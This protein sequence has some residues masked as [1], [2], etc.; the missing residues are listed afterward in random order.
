MSP[1]ISFYIFIG[2][3]SIDMFNDFTFFEDYVYPPFSMEGISMTQPAYRSRCKDR[4]ILQNWLKNERYLLDK[5]GWNLQLDH[6]ND[7]WRCISAHFWMIF[8][9]M[10]NPSSVR[11]DCSF[12]NDNAFRSSSLD[13][14]LLPPFGSSYTLRSFPFRA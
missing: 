14:L 7:G 10:K 11:G 13:Y 3:L 12:Y 4:V 9:Q 6:F 2:D 5:W 1:L 8:F